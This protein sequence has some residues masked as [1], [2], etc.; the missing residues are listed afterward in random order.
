MEKNKILFVTGGSSGIGNAVLNSFLNKGLEC[1]NLDV[2]G[3]PPI[4]VRNF[5]DVKNLFDNRVIS[6][7]NFLL[8][9]AGVAYFTDSQG[10]I[11]DFANA[12]IEQLH[13]MVQVNL[14]GQINILQAFIGKVIQKCGSGNIVVISSI[15]ADFSG[16]PNMAVYDATKAAITALAKSL[17]PYQKNDIRINILQP[18]SIRTTIG[19]WNPD[20]TINQAGLDIVK[21]GQDTDQK[22]LGGKEVSLSQIVNWVNFLFFSDHGANGAVITIDEGLTLMGREDY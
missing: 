13:A 17:V 19:G 21:I 22:K 6:G 4:D 3:N 11:V 8:A 12:P 10:K 16:G 5:S 2:R 20:G 9:N 18:G 14:I 1:V 15:S 7:K